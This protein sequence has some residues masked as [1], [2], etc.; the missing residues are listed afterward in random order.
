MIKTQELTTMNSVVTWTYQKGKPSWKKAWTGWKR[1]LSRTVQSSNLYFNKAKCKVLEWHYQRTQ[2]RL[3]SM[4]LGR[5][6]AE[7]VLGFLVDHRMNKSQQIQNGSCTASQGALLAE[8]EIRSSHSVLVR[9]CLEYI[10]FNSQPH[11]S[12][13]MQIDWTCS[14]GRPQIR[15]NGWRICPVRKD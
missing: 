1:V 6:L 7:R 4:W 12:R 2:S 10:V 3:E 14:K 9:P 11:S 5:S 8:T 13:K 15:S